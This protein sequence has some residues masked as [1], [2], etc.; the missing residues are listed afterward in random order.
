MYRIAEVLDGVVLV[1]KGITSKPEVLLAW[2]KLW[3]EIE[4]LMK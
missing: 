3:Q 2:S 1:Q 4:P